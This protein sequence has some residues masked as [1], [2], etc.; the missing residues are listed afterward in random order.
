[1]NEAPP[2]LLTGRRRVYVNLS[3]ESS[4]SSPAL[5]DVVG[6]N[7]PRLQPLAYVF[8]RHLLFIKLF[9]WPDECL[10]NIRLW[11]I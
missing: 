9:L 8:M 3:F 10:W 6:D 2:Q 11:Y 7:Q 1:M 5:G 4:N